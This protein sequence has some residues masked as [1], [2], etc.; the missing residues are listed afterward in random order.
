MVFKTIVV[1]TFILRR[2]RL[3]SRFIWKREYCPLNAKNL[4]ARQ[5][6]NL[7]IVPRSLDLG[8]LGAKKKTNR[9]SLCVFDSTDPAKK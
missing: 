2:I 5:N 6:R 1:I 9:S 8:R 3:P 4:T 7:I